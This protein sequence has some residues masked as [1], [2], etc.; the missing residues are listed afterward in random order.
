M[1]VGI[2]EARADIVMKMDA[3]STYDAKYVVQCISHMI[4][5]DADAVG[6][7]LV[8]L[9]RDPTTIGRA[10]ALTLSHPFGAGNSYFRIGSSRPRWADAAAFGCYK[11][12]WLNRIGLYN[13]NLVRSSD[14]D[15][16]TRLRHAGGRI[17]LV[18]TAVGYYYAESDLR[19]FWRRNI[20]DGIWATF[21]LRYGRRVF[22]VRH[23]TPGIF[24]L[25][26]SCSAAFALLSPRIRS[27]LLS[28]LAL[29]GTVG[30]VSG[31]QIAVRER[32][33]RML[34]L[35]FFISG[36]RHVAYG[37]GSLIGIAKALAGGDAT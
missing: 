6:G 2:R 5:Y 32:D 31:A 21:P 33:A 35:V 30:L 12:A 16:N 24:L 10:I 8:T 22:S 15:L 27:M 13:E 26:L 4:A 1:N 37:I 7:V 20:V 34:P 23:L 9:P 14:A 25:Y 19:R 11:K 3:H 36:M 17:L 18:P 29:Y 28:T